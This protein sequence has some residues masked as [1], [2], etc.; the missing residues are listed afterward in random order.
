MFRVR[1]TSIIVAMIVFLLGTFLQ[2]SVGIAAQ[3][4]DEVDFDKII[5]NGT[6]IDGSGLSKY[7]AD[8]GIRNGIIAHI[9]DLRDYVAEKEVDANG[10]FV[11]PGFIDLHSHASTSALQEAQSSLT[12]GVTTEMLNVDGGGPTDLQERFALEDAGLG[13]NIGAHIGFNSV[14]EEVI[15]EEDREAT[16]EEINEMQKLIIQGMEDGGF[17][18][19]AGLFYRPAY[20]AT[21]EEVIDVVS[22]ADQWRTY[23][24]HHI[25][26]E[27]NEVVEATAETIEIGEEAGLV[28]HITHMKVMG[29]DNWG[30][31]AETV[32][33]IEEA[34]ARG[35]YATADV[36]PYIRSQTGLTAIVPPWVEDGG[37]DAMLE[38]FSDPELRPQIAEEIEEIMHSRVEGPE[39]VYFPT[40]QMTLADYMEEGFNYDRNGQMLLS[41]LNFDYDSDI[42]IDVD[43]VN[44]K[45]SDGDTAFAYDFAGSDEWESEAFDQLSSYPSNAVSYLV[46]ENKGKIHIDERTQGNA[47]AYGK[48]TPVMEELENNSEAYMRFRASDVDNDQRLRFWLQADDFSSGSSFPVNGYGIELHLGT[49]TI[50]LYGREDGNSTNY[51]SVDANMTTDWQSLRIR[52]EDDQLMVR[53]WNDEEEE[54]DEWNMV[55]EIPAP[56]EDG[57]EEELTPGE[58]TMRILETEGSLRSIYSFGHEEDFARILQNPTTAIASDGGATTSSSTHPRRYG[59]Q[60]RALSQ[61]VREEGLTDW[62]TMVQKMT[63]LPATI[64]G[65]TDRGFIAEGMAADITIFDPDTI[66]DNGTFDEPKQYADGIDY[67]LVNGDFALEDGELTGLQSGKALKRAANMPTR[68]MTT[69]S[70]DVKEEGHLY[71]IDESDVLTGVEMELSI[72]QGETD[73]NADG[74]FTVQDEDAEMNFNAT[75]FGKVQVTDGWTSFTGRGLLNENEERTFM[76]IIDENETM[77]TDKRPTVTIQIEG[78]NEIR[79]FLGEAEP[80]SIEDMKALVDEFRSDEDIGSDESAGKLQTHLT[81]IAHYESTGSMDKAIRHLNSFKQLL[82][83]QETNGEISEEAAVVL[84]THADHILEAW[85]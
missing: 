63:G 1:Q 70:V 16:E 73:K 27:N 85:Q 82:D 33:M 12:Q 40:K 29:P 81:T 22:V 44:V 79:G 47:S 37:R 80:L 74:S 49:D 71:K 48:I 34:N 58:T 8:I 14:W 28:P 42:T 59:T 51:G 54:P 5:R 75:G 36:Y 30:K 56:Q 78:E 9:G 25:R 83:Y 43:E 4:Q 15:G 6:I 38:R 23:F 17:G 24:Q 41:V 66:V 60:P 26:N 46:E 84:A 72:Q 35:T 7:E 11:S 76:V 21:T 13:I 19:S 18:V 61:Y 39:D 20:Y 62:E 69:E 45:D 31:S 65:M 32:G 53:L 10:L 50:A 67:V 52:V 77:A 3:S 2:G 55:Q 68:P 64:S 57:E